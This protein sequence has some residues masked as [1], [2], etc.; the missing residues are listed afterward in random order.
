MILDR[1]FPPPRIL[2]V[3]RPR[4]P[5][6][7]WPELLEQP[8]VLAAA[9]AALPPPRHMS[10]KGGA[11][12]GR[13]AHLGR[14]TR[15]FFLRGGTELLSMDPRHC[16]VWNVATRA[17]IATFS[18]QSNPSW[19]AVPSN[20]ERI[21]LKQFLGG[22]TLRRLPDGEIIEQLE[23]P[24]SAFAV[25]PA[26]QVLFM[27]DDCNNVEVRDLASLRVEGTLPM[28]SPR[29]LAASPDRT[30]VAGVRGESTIEVWSW[31][32]RTL[33]GTFEAP[34]KVTDLRF[35]GDGTLVLAVGRNRRLACWSTTDLSP[36]SSR[37]E[38][39]P[40]CELATVAR[41]SEFYTLD[42]H[43]RMARW[44]RGQLDQRTRRNFLR[45][46][47]ISPD[48]RKLAAVHAGDGIKVFALPGLETIDRHV[49]DGSPVT[50]FAFGEDSCT[51]VA[52]SMLG[53]VE[54]WR[55]EHAG[56]ETSSSFESPQ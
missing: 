29:L 21:L 53:W 33:R 18:H 51:L 15:L 45:G 41:S 38:T 2:S 9:L 25:D 40:L 42:A 34:T 13:P 37:R 17:L 28:R 19:V 44:R 35:N 12:S 3:A 11:T 55:L 31:P 48:G 1:I 54:C 27:L 56:R 24:S 16:K 23:S 8:E 5:S 20:G 32:D 39:G 49:V 4:V 14:I 47:Q 10:R 43:G 26:G 30:S 52:G 36:V 6:P 7:A 50:A 46:I 22:V